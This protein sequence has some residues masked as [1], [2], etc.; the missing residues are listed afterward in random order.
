MQEIL[1][2]HPIQTRAP[3]LP[4]S[5]SSRTIRDLPGGTPTTHERRRTDCCFTS[6]RFTKIYPAD[7][8][9]TLT[10]PDGQTVTRKF[11]NERSVRRAFVK[12]GS[13][14]DD[15]NSTGSVRGGLGRC[16][17]VDVA[18]I[19]TASAK[20]VTV[21]YYFQVCCDDPKARNGARLVHVEPPAS[22]GR[23]ES[24]LPLLQI[25]DIEK[26]PCP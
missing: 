3:V 6:I 26:A 8:T 13:G 15:D 1:G 11:T 25:T 24:R 4:S 20:L 9:V 14:D 7:M 5:G 21:H 18:I 17:D 10:T 2:H 23:T 12:P 22:P 16:V 19:D